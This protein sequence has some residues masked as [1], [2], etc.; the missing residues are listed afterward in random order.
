MSPAS[1]AASLKSTMVSGRACWAWISS[2]TASSFAG[3]PETLRGL[4]H[5]LAGL[6]VGSAGK[7][8]LTGLEEALDGVEDLARY[9]LAALV[10]QSDR[11]AADDEHGRRGRDPRLS[12]SPLEAVTA[13]LAT[14]RPLRS[15]LGQLIGLDDEIV[16]D[17]LVEQPMAQ[18]CAE[19]RIGLRAFGLA[20]VCRELDVGVDLG[21]DRAVV[22]LE[23]A[24]E[25]LGQ[26]PLVG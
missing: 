25:L 7:R 6:P 23:G 22:L 11:T 2:V 10:S 19:L 15:A 5:Q 21:R 14:R 24:G 1:L 20:E 18:G 12:R 3:L 17:Q 26:P 8:R 16:L 4:L 9:G 13:T